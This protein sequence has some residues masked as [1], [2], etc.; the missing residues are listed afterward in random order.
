[1]LDSTELYRDWL[2]RGATVQLLEHAISRTIEG[3]AIPGPAFEELIANHERQSEEALARLNKAALECQRLGVLDPIPSRPPFDYRA[4]VTELWDESLGFTILRWPT[5]TH[6]ELVSRATTRTAPFDHKGGGYRDALVWHS[7]L[8]LARAGKDVVLVSADRAF[9]D[10]GGGLAQSLREETAPLAGSVELVRDLAPWLLNHLPW[11]NVSTNDALLKA[12]DD[13][14]RSYFLKSDFQDQ[15]APDAEAIGFDRAPYHFEID[16]IQWNGGLDRVSVRRTE[17]GV[18][19]IQYDIGEVVEFT[20][21]LPDGSRLEPHWKASPA[22]YPAQILVH[23]SVDLTLRVG[24]LFEAG[25]SFAFD[26]FSWRRTDGTGSGA[27]V[28]A[29]DPGAALFEF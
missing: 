1:M 25:T 14:F 9:S 10:G 4:Y 7:A 21:L 5:V 20:A 29:H 18:N 24:V 23:G 15:I 27:S 28:Q 17:D 13:T 19:F 22:P 3:V 11:E 26:D 16:D 2:F 12:R 6:E 8:E